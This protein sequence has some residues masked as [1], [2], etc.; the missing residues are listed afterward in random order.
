M[1]VH[2]TSCIPKTLA[3]LWLIGSGCK[4]TPAIAQKSS[5]PESTHPPT[6]ASHPPSTQRS[7][8]A[9]VPSVQT[10][11]IDPDAAPT[12]P[13]SEPLPKSA[14][15]C[16]WD[17]QHGTTPETQYEHEWSAMLDRSRVVDIDHD[18]LDDRIVNLGACGNWG[19][20]IQV[21]LLGCEDERYHPVW[22][23]DYAQVIGV[24]PGQGAWSS[25]V[26]TR[27]GSDA[28][29][30]PT[31]AELFEAKLADDSP[32][33]FRWVNVESCGLAER[34]SIWRSVDCNLPPACASGSV[35]ETY[36]KNQ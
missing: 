3:L 7:A 29:C 18:G 5:A 21:V 11:S 14:R 15:T 30:D 9:P 2:F 24:V 16:T 33:G 35:L 27:R 23:P 32:E 19:D 25:L 28:G 31:Y 13:E 22:G 4:P 34:M 17:A 6:S 36:Q 20:C 10:T 1:T 26:F 12:E 8:R